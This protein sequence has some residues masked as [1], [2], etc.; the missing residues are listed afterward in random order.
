MR[1][2]YLQ[3]CGNAPLHTDLLTF[4][5][6]KLGKSNIY[7]FSFSKVKGCY[8]SVC[9]ITHVTKI[10]KMTWV[11]CVFSLSLSLSLSLSVQWDEANFLCQY[12]FK[13]ELKN[14]LAL[15]SFL[16]LC[17]QLGKHKWIVRIENGNG[18]KDLD[19][20]PGVN[21]AVVVALEPRLG[22]RARQ[23]SCTIVKK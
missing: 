6:G 11:F 4:W 1:R 5:W 13:S 8:S 17:F 20:P 16:L 19:G 10:K 12:F 23:G 2:R 15:H 18:S 22:F 14:F 21:W 3:R 7:F 9:C